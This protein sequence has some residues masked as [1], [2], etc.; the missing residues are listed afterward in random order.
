MSSL[1]FL[2]DKSSIGDDAARVNLSFIDDGM[3]V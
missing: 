3:V 2:R 1:T